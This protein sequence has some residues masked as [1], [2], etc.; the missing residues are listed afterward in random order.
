MRLHSR[1]ISQKSKSNRLTVLSLF[2]G[3]LFVAL[4]G[5]L[6]FVQIVAHDYYK[7]LADDQQLLTVESSPYRG[8]I[9][10]RDHTNQGDG[11][12]YVLA[13]NKTFYEIY[14][15][16]MQVTRPINTA[17]SLSQILGT[18]YQTML[19]RAK[20]EN[21]PYEPVVSRATEEQY[22]ALKATGIPGIYGRE[23]IWRY[24]PDSEIGSQVL[25]FLGIEENKRI[26]KYGIEGYWDAELAGASEE[27]TATRD[28]RGTVLPRLEDTS[29][30]SRDGSDLVLTIDRTAEYEVCSM[31]KKGV[32]KYAADKGSVIVMESKTGRILVMCN[33]PAFDPNEYQLVQEVAN[34]NND[35]VFESYEPGSVFK[36]I[37]MGI[38]IDREA[39]TPATT[40]ED[41]GEVII[42]DKPI[43]NFD[44]LAHGKKTMTQ[45]LQESLNTGVIFATKTV[46]NRVYY[47]YV[48]NFGFGEKTGIEIAQESAGNLGK[49]ETAKDIYKATTSFGQGL[50]VTPLQMIAG[51]NVFANDGVLIRPYIV[52][53]IR[54][55]DGERI[56]TKPQNVRRVV[57][58]DTART[59]TAMLIKVAEEGYD[60]KATI[61]GYYVTG[62]T[63][64]AQIAERGSYGSKTNHTF[65]GFAPATDAKFSIIIK[66]N[67]V[68]NVPFASDST[69][70]LF[71][72]M[73]RFLLQYYRIPPTR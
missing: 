71:N 8:E 60:H 13:S 23:H 51:V 26:G 9:L 25:G 37:A 36:P 16:P 69:A 49:L 56:V 7:A 40:Y 30:I 15:N 12:T 55:P 20:K 14:L 38:A 48:K 3:L 70:P 45:V 31:L 1:N 11:V 65:V 59:I 61:P 63:G 46:P 73:A 27:E 44:S 6:F 66:L 34:F 64:T 43:H 5:R 35:A 72:A 28:A 41:T 29:V 24:Y 21:D 19:D 52:E 32:E 68:K 58:S 22:Q 50:T 4:I 10:S 62:K 53:E 67:N 33:Y 54:K 47:E 39:V 17:E 18:D 42:D 2:L 57:T